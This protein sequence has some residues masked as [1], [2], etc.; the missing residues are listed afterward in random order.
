MQESEVKVAANSMLI[1]SNGEAGNSSPALADPSLTEGAEIVTGESCPP[2]AIEESVLISGS[3]YDS[4]TTA[5]NANAEETDKAENAQ[6]STTTDTSCN[7]TV[8]KEAM[9]PP[10]KGA[11]TTETTP[12]KRP[13]KRAKSTDS[14]SSNACAKRVKPNTPQHSTAGKSVSRVPNFQSGP[15]PAVNAGGG[16]GDDSFM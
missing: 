14:V 11:K 12:K 16:F 10:V 7:D 2:T 6:A 9:K 15:S 1:D 3:D 4:D 5:S 13:P 8:Q